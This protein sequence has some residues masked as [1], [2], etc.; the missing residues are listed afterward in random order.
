MLLKESAEAISSK[1]DATSYSM[2]MESFVSSMKPCCLQVQVQEH[3]ISI[4]PNK[5]KSEQ[6]SHVTSYFVCKTLKEDF[7]DITED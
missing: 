7:R 3:F 4:I 1:V 2:L 6:V 5:P